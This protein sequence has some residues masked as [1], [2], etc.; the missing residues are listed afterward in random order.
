MLQFIYGGD[1]TVTAESL[2]LNVLDVEKVADCNG[3]TTNWVPPH[4]RL[5]S[6]SSR[7]RSI[8]SAS[9]PPTPQERTPI[10]NAMTAH[11][12][13]FAIAE[14]YKL[15]ELKA[16]SLKKFKDAKEDLTIEGFLALTKAVYRNTAIADDSLREELLRMLLAQYH[17]WLHTEKFS[18]A[19]A[20]DA[21]LHEFAVAVVVALSK[22][23]AK[24]STKDKTATEAQATGSKLLLSDLDQA[25]EALAKSSKRIRTLEADAKT[26]QEVI[27][28]VVDA[29][30]RETKDYA[31][32]KDELTS[33]LNQTKLK[34]VQAERAMKN[35]GDD[36]GKLEVDLKNSRDWATKCRE[37]ASTKESLLRDTK[38]E[39][40]KETARANKNQ[41]LCIQKE[42]I[43]LREKIRA[44]NA[45]KSSTAHTQEQARADKA[46]KIIQS[47]VSTVNGV[48][49]CDD[50][51]ESLNFR[52]MA[53]DR[54]AREVPFN[55]MLQC[56][57]CSEITYGR[58]IP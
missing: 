25:N 9:T 28:E 17:E 31:R 5:I 8:E 58:R 47:I 56:C 38:E 32:S 33:T 7:S 30:A 57:N 18:S 44:D 2:Q 34:L 15:P 49:S 20:N 45:A 21:N 6:G 36:N 37:K 3:V 4:R 23:S 26:L 46:V 54:T 11:V 12:L 35:L 50:C 10:T 48:H 51:G 53:D 19:L 13:V 14:H 1:Y 43:I 52:L 40:K 55:S 29:R 16:L 42:T 22:K 27:T 41:D 24:K 39:L